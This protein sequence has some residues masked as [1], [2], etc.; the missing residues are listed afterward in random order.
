MTW[1]HAEA[2]D[3]GGARSLASSF[4]ALGWALL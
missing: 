3:I 1:V 4:Y 2:D